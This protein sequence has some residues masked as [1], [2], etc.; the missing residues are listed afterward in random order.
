MEGSWTKLFGWVDYLFFA[1][2]LLISSLVGVYHAW[3]G[4]SNSTSDYLMGGKKM[5]MFPVAMSLA[6]RYKP[7]FLASSFYSGKI[8]V[9][10]KIFN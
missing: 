9:Y 2:T 5:P 6:A 3:R 4:A 1:L 10:N 7:C 8:H